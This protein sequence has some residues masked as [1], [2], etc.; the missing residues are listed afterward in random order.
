[1][2]DVID[3]LRAYAEAAEAT[4]PEQI[5]GPDRTG[6]GRVLVALAAAV[7]VVIGVIAVV[8]LQ[9]PD[10]PL[11]VTSGS[12]TSAT[13]ASS[14]QPIPP[15]GRWESLAAAPIDGRVGH[16][17]VATDDELIVWGGRHPKELGDGAAW[18]FSEH[19]WRTLPPSPLSPRTD[20]VAVWTGKEVWILG[21]AE[22]ER[23]A[24][25][26]D[27][28]TNRWRRLPDLPA[29]AIAGQT[30]AVWTGDE[31]VLTGLTGDAN[32]YLPTTTYALRDGKWLPLRV[33]P[34]QSGGT[35]AA[36]V[37]TGDE[38]LRV[39]FDD[40]LTRVFAYNPAKDRWR[41]VVGAF[42]LFAHPSEVAWTG[43][44]LVIA[45]GSGGVAISTS[46]A[47]T[48]LPESG[49]ADVWPAQ[50]VGSVVTLGDRYLGPDGRWHDAAEV[51]DHRGFPGAVVHDGRYY[52]WGGE[53][54]RVQDDC[55]AFVPRT[56]LLVWT[57]PTVEEPADS[58]TT[59]A[60]ARPAVELSAEMGCAPNDQL[61]VE[62]VLTSDRGRT[63]TA[64]VVVAGTA[65]DSVVAGPHDVDLRAGEP[66]TAF[67]VFN[68]NI[69]SL[70]TSDRLTV[71]VL[72]P[73]GSLV[74]SVPVPIT[75][76]LCG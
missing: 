17:M 67:M 8:V 30:G 16:V 57:P 63:V 74:A 60:P 58:T 38:V 3:Q 35:S 53:A 69:D 29:A 31:L 40:G 47:V 73:G 44:R 25:A 64:D 51:P 76:P 48:R 5:P 72:E 75:H 50:S 26:Y 15:G 62:M 36:A 59:T 42:G 45:G 28:A 39:A 32:Q 7:S 37:W 52:V 20:P 49:G 68:G 18:S 27:P 24:A 43:Q 61:A 70:H 19:R 23:D 33:G 12:P 6:R 71:R 9:K 14:T 11:P 65:G 10:A 56:A 1:V 66:L 22:R 54:C 55:V 2:P 34:E 13:T 4:V 46:G 21:G 41:E